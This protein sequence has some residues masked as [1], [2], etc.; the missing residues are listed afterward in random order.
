MKEIRVKGQYDELKVVQA[1]L[2]V[3]IAAKDLEKAIAGLNMQ[4]AHHE[5]EVEILKEDVDQEFK[6]AMRS[7]KVSTNFTSS[8]HLLFSSFE[9]IKLFLLLCNE[10]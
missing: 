9:M 6:S 1:A 3:K 2:G 5:D 7:I 4:V 10:N 8:I